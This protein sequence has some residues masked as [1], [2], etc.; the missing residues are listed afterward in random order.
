MR[1]L[2]GQPFPSALGGR[3]DGCAHRAW[4]VSASHLEYSDAVADTTQNKVLDSQCFIQLHCRPRHKKAIEISPFFPFISAK[5]HESPEF[6]T[7]HYLPWSLQGKK[8]V[9]MGKGDEYSLEN[10]TE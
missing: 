6:Q 3:E 5:P 2:S 7:C 4:P 1:T 8:G 10:P 9:G